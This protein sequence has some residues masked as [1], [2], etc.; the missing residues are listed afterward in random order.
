MEKLFTDKEYSDKAIEA[1][2]QGNRLYIYTHMV[3]YEAEVLE[4]DYIDKE[5]E[6]Q[7]VDEEGN[8]MYD[9]DGNPIMEIVVIQVPVPRMVEVE[10]ERQKVDEEGNP[11]Y[12]EEGNPIMETVTIEVQAHHTETFQKEVAELVIADYGYYVCYKE[13]YT[14]GTINPNY[15]EEKIQKERARLDA[16]TLTPSDVE[17]ALYYSDLEMDFDDLKA[18]IKEQAP[19]IDIKGLAIE[20]RAN[21]FYRGAVDKNGNRIIDMVGLLLGYNPADMDYLFINKKLPVNE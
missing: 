15:E 6:R 20:F 18:L 12:D 16:L 5:V 21:N 17:R 8:P 1:N 19:Q 11:M 9:K 14:D 4:W 2:F 7:K 13:N 3:D 10:V